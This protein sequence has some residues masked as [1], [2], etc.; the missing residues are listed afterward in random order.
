MS[1]TPQVVPEGVNASAIACGP[2]HSAFV[3]DGQLYSYGSNRHSK[4]GRADSDGSERSPQP[5]LVEASDGH[6]PAVA[7]IALGGNHSAAITEGGVLWTWGYGGSL[8]HGAGGCGQ[9]RRGE[10]S[11]PEMVMPFVSQGIEVSQVACGDLHTLVL[12]RQGRVHSTGQGIHGVLG[13]GGLASTGEELDFQEVVYFRK[14]T[15]SIMAPGLEPQIIKLD[16][17]RE[18]SAAMSSHGELWVWGRN[19]YGQLG[20]GFEVMK[21]RD[22]CMKYPFLM[23]QLPMEGHVFRDFACGDRHMVAVT[24]AGACHLRVGRSKEL[25][26]HGHHL[27]ESV[28]GRLERCLEGGRWRRLFLRLDTKWRVVLLGSSLE[29]LPGTAE[30]RGRRRQGRQGPAGAAAPKGALRG[31]RWRRCARAGHCGIQTAMF[32]HHREWMI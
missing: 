28:P 14:T 8:W 29:W 18:F 7:S 2:T 27:A 26:A 16:A 15:D 10:V 17:G 22:F 25:R 13:R 3:V 31:F 9:G 19:D 11:R 32:G 5:V 30:R 12:D 23:R 6:R 1:R 4:L 24:T 21:D 20:M